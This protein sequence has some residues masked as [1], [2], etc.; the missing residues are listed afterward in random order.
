[1]D[2]RT[3]AVAGRAV[4]LLFAVVWGFFVAFNVVFSDVFGLG[5]MVGAV[6]FVAVA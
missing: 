6:G 5:D 4:A 3:A 2:G 1:M